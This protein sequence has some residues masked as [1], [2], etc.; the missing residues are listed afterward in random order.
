MMDLLDVIGLLLVMM[1][2]E[3][4]VIGLMEIG[5]WIDDRIIVTIGIILTECQ[6]VVSKMYQVNQ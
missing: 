4:I 5:I 3:L 2:I 6:Y 1:I